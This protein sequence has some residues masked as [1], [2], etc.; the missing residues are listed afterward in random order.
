MLQR[1]MS[2]TSVQ[3]LK[4]WYSWFKEGQFYIY[5]IVYTLVRMAINVV[6]TVQSFYLIRVLKFEITERFPSPLAVAITPL[7]S[8]SVSLLF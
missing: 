6:L 5:C 3:E 1:A 2:I 8:Y 4:E 7:I